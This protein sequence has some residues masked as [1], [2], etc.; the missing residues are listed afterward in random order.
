MGMILS[1]FQIINP[2]LS[3]G[4][5]FPDATTGRRFNYYYVI[6]IENILMQ[7]PLTPCVF[8]DLFF[9]NEYMHYPEHIGN[10]GRPISLLAG[11]TGIQLKL[12]AGKPVELD[13]KLGYFASRF[14]YPVAQ[15]SG[16]ITSESIFKQSLGGGIAMNILRC[17]GN[18]RVG[19]RIYGNIIPFRPQPVVQPHVPLYLNDCSLTSFGAGLLI[20]FLH[21]EEQ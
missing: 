16:V 20:G 8:A 4:I 1:L 17:F 2:S 7:E 12:Y 10:S 14:Y 3:A 6:E 15:D 21:K 9:K 11:G 5:L 18:K 13:F 19:V